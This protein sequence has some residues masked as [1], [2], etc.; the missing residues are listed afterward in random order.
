M[1]HGEG[2]RTRSTLERQEERYGAGSIYEGL[3]EERY[4]E[5][6]AAYRE[7]VQQYYFGEGTPEER[8][9]AAEQQRQERLARIKADAD[10]K[11][12][13][14]A[15]D[16][17]L[18]LSNGIS[19]INTK[20]ALAR[21]ARYGD[22]DQILA[23]EAKLRVALAKAKAD[24]EAARQ[25]KESSL[26]SK[27]ARNVLKPVFARIEDVTEPFQRAYY[28]SQYAQNKGA[29]MPTQLR[30]L[31]GSLPGFGRT[32]GRGGAREYAEAVNTREERDVLSKNKEL[33]SFGQVTT[34]W[35]PKTD[36]RIPGTNQKV[37]ARGVAS[38]VV[39]LAFQVLM[40]PTTYISYGSSQFAKVGILAEKAG[41]TA[42]KRAGVKVTREEAARIGR[43]A[44]L[45]GRTAPRLIDAVV[46][47]TRTSRD[48]TALTKA[49]DGLAPPAARAIIQA[50]RTG[51]ED[52]VRAA[53]QEA[54]VSG[55]WNP[56][57][58]TLRQITGLGIERAVTP[59]GLGIQPALRRV[60]RGT[61]AGLAS[62]TARTAE[63]ALE[64]A[65]QRGVQRAGRFVGDIAP[66]ATGPTTQ[67]RGPI[68]LGRR[69]EDLLDYLDTSKTLPAAAKDA[70]S[71]EIGRI[72]RISGGFREQ[73]SIARPGGS[74]LKEADTRLLRLERLRAVMEGRLGKEAASQAR[75]E[76]EQGFKVAPLK[77][78]KLIE[79]AA[80]TAN[81]E[82]PQSAGLGKDFN[83][84]ELRHT[85]SQLDE[86][87][88][89]GLREALEKSVKFGV[90]KKTGKP[91]YRIVNRAGL[92][93]VQRAIQLLNDPDVL[94]EA[95]RLGGNVADRAAQAVPPTPARPGLGRRVAQA[96]ARALLSTSESIAPPSVPFEGSTMKG[97]LAVLRAEGVDRWGRTV[98]LDDFTLSS[99]R[100][101]VEVAKTE[102]A[103]Y[104]AIEQGVRRLAV[105]EGVDGDDLVAIYRAN[106][107]AAKAEQSVHRAMGADEAGQ[108]I[109]DHEF[110]LAQRISNIP[111]FDP[112]DIK[113]SIKLL[114]EGGAGDFAA[115]IAAAEGDRSKMLAASKALLKKG[116][117]AWKLN[118]VTNAYAPVLG[119]V[120]GIGFSDGDLGDR[121]KA[122][123]I[124]AGIGMF[125]PG[126]YVLRVAITEERL[127]RYYMARGVVQHA[128]EWVPGLSKWWRRHG[129]DR[130]FVSQDLVRAGKVGEIRIGES[131]ATRESGNFVVAGNDNTPNPTGWNRIVSVVGRKEAR[132][133]TGWERIVNYQ[134]HPESD[135]LARIF[136]NARAGVLTRD[137]AISNAKA[138]LKTPDGKVIRQR[139]SDGVGGTSN[140]KEIMERYEEFINKHT[141]PDLARLRLENAEAAANGEIRN[142]TRE[143]LK[144]VPRPERPDFIH[145]ERTWIIPKNAGQVRETRNQILDK[146]VFGGPS[147]KFSRVPLAE[148]IY[149]DE[150]LRLRRNG[151]PAD[152]A[153][154][155][156]DFLATKRTNEI[157]FRVQDESRFA[158]NVDFIAPF[159]Q[160]KEELFRVWGKLVKQNPGRALRVTRMAAL[161][162]NNGQ[163]NGIFTEN[164]W[165][166]WQLSVPHGRLGSALIGVNANFDANLKDLLFFTQ[167][168]FGGDLGVGVPFPTPGGPWVTT[169]EKHLVTNHPDLYHEMP[170]WLKGALFPYGIQGSFTPG[171]QR[172]LWMGLTGKPPPWEFA[173]KEDQADQLRKWNNEI[174]QQL[175][176]QHWQK[177]GDRNWEPS[178][179]E[180]K[181]A[182]KS[183]F[184]LWALLGSTFPAA[185]TPTLQGK[186]AFDAVVKANTKGVDPLT[187]KPKVNWNA[188]RADFPLSDIYLTDNNEY[189]GPD[190][191]KHWTTADDK[192]AEQYHTHQRRHLSLEQFRA[193][194]A[195]ARKTSEAFREFNNILQGK[196]PW[197]MEADLRDWRQ[198]YPKLAADY[199]SDYFKEQELSQIL[200]FPPA[201]R[202]HLVDQWRKEYNVTY[203][204]FKKLESRL[205]LTGFRR[206]P[207]RE[208]RYPEEVVADVS[209]QIRRGAQE[210]VYVSTLLPAE[211]VSYWKE[212][213]SQ[214]QYV[215]GKKVSAEDVTNQYDLYGSYL[216]NLY[217]QYPE[218]RSSKKKSRWDEAIDEWKGDIRKQV[219]AAFEELNRVKA[220]RTEA[221]EAKNWTAYYALKDKQQ[222][223]SDHIRALKNSVYQAVPD[224]PDWVGDWFALAAQSQGKSINEMFNLEA[225]RKESGINWISTD[226]Q[227]HYL[228][229]PGDVREAYVQDLVTNL[230]QE[231]FTTGKLY[232]EW[233][234]DFQRD[235]LRRNM[236]AGQIGDWMADTVAGS[237]S[238]GR[239]SSGRRGR[240]FTPFRTRSGNSVPSELEYAYD[241]FKEYDRRNG[242]PKPAAW[243]EYLALPRNPA[244]RAQF[245]KNH[246]EVATYIKLGPM[247]NMPELHRLIV[248]N[249][250]VKYGK[251]EG[252]ELS[253]GEV[254]DLAFAREQLARW[255]RRPEGV[256][257]PSSYDLWL[258]MPTGPEKAAF[259]KAHPEIGDWLRLG[260]M[261]NMPEEYRNVVRDIMFRYGEWT[262]NQDPLGEV[263]AGFYRVPR[264]ARQQY[265]KEHPEL[266]AYWAALRSPEDQRL[267][268]LADQYFSIGAPAARRAFLSANPD[269]QAFFVDSRTKRYE[270]F[271]NQVAQY[272][273][274]NPELFTQYLERQ[275]E[276]LSE[277]LRRFAEPGIMRETVR[278]VAKQSTRRAET[279]RAA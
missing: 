122:G 80:K 111:L 2:D 161:A 180:V 15:A 162:F 221:A 112:D 1:A 144:A 204:E 268:N 245:L 158:K 107:A 119:A 243:A 91:T 29:G 271:L 14:E 228:A 18:G 52:A 235:L 33:F 233:L 232:W 93:R 198:K 211:Q 262:Q 224:L 131:Y 146:L 129:L 230:N 210:E 60:A 152:E 165:G 225:L 133:L 202:D 164:P 173:S 273:G 272:M 40:D 187:G 213:Q 274:A 186:E 253:M 84:I 168:A 22:V 65:L 234:T 99:L 6:S 58:S 240:P 55:R 10:A 215:A 257:R 185:P 179:E 17:L 26:K 72:R 136:L 155:T 120:A 209:K 86:S 241:L 70:F 264:H 125:G 43:E 237:S 205:S 64:N 147:T 236:P 166:D 143:E 24:A 89:V 68:S 249:I 104:D 103:V 148:S 145:A 28:A 153:Q 62:T 192:K 74:A 154:E 106:R 110:T 242:M 50:A 258:A 269:L 244:V 135:E 219:S 36:W 11:I 35:V 63:Q 94:D 67:G 263:I 81:V 188:V 212:K 77:G 246:P 255:N 37:N 229:M 117:H 79:Q 267:H 30:A 176:Y 130:P 139:L 207:Y 220:A 45:S 97:Q 98:G 189:V 31:A 56:T 27:I 42:A 20:Q 191:F 217:K 66:M 88:A 201:T 259:L 160:P 54:F 124:G 19:D 32:L 275:T 206:D 184:K 34:Q 172:R 181:K 167:G 132:H 96:G 216:S 78:T 48:I 151:I 100:Q 4:A 214:L 108:A 118:I 105:K 59:R 193:E 170:D 101:A 140:P 178:P 194:I 256:D 113:R 252:E 75:A 203:K 87:V 16:R 276:V 163:T 159:Q 222:A 138:F 208:A 126:R 41:M 123:A 9:A 279:R 7:E 260:P 266:E 195:E 44:I 128:P 95:L 85:L 57:V 226:E 47:A 127:L 196:N 92:G 175:R 109:R 197:V 183:L 270:S 200:A 231:A 277:L 21:I 39:D 265:L 150:Y 49:V 51:D 137:E 238:G 223:L 156:A 90:S 171:P 12:Y 218:L 83:A 149:R 251:W 278:G 3:S 115:R 134:I 157:M 227:A 261:A 190:D 53:A 5:E 23:T 142:I 182:T 38:G 76:L 169:I 73:P 177:T 114:K 61:G 69:A 13:Q 174:Y 248:S 199:R 250:M 82:I 8:E 239:T 121:L 116:H 46:D 71:E 141:T 247:A 102:Q 25:K 254:T